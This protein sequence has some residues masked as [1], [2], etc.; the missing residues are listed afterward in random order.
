MNVFNYGNSLKLLIVSLLG[1]LEKIDLNIK[2]SHYT[3]QGFKT[4]SS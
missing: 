4:E 3:L 1:I 2:N